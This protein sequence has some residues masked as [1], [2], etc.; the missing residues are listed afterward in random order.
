MLSVTA[1]STGDLL[2]SLDAV[3]TALSITTTEEDDRLTAAIRAASHAVASYL[4][5]YPLRQTY[6]ETVPGY[7]DLKL[8]VSRIP[9]VS[10]DGMYYGSTGEI[11]APTSYTIDNSEAGFIMRDLG[12]P[13]S[14]GVEWDMESHI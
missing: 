13:W 7:G 9:V 10:V 11:V 4:G 2:T 8:M 5:Y 1:A 12:F 3:K 14:A 6:R